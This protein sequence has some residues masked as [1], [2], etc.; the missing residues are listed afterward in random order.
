[1]VPAVEPQ[2]RR[3][4]GLSGVADAIH[5]RLRAHPGMLLPTPFV[6]GMALRMFEARRVIGRRLSRRH[7]HVDPAKLTLLTH[8][9]LCR[10]FTCDRAAHMAQG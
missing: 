5:P 10:W 6:P 7:F 3:A 1:V 4:G 2:L 8:G 9:R